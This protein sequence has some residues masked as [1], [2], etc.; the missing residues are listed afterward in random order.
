MEM[1]P[2]PGFLC[3]PT[4]PMTYH[5]AKIYSYMPVAYITTLCY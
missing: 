3:T 1:D 4:I 5:C 2:M